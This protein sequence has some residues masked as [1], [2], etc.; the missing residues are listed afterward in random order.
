MSSIEV[1]QQP[2]SVQDGELAT[3]LELIRFYAEKFIRITELLGELIRRCLRNEAMRA[4]GWV[5]PNDADPGE[6]VQ[7]DAGAIFLNLLVELG[8]AHLPF[9]VLCTLRNS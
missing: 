7:E 2:F 9:C 3:L 5:L 4:H 6:L 8:S 1:E